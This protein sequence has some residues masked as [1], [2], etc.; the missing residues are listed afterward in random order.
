MEQSF[1]CLRSCS[2]SIR[3]FSRQRG[4]DCAYV[5]SACR[6]SRTS[7]RRCRAPGDGSAAYRSASIHS[8]APAGIKR[9][10]RRDWGWFRS[11][12]TVMPPKLIF[13][14]FF[15]Y[16]GI[17]NCYSTHKANVFVEIPHTSN[18]NTSHTLMQLI[19]P[20]RELF[21]NYYY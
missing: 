14:V 1:G 5:S 21:V 17:F 13:R 18:F 11:E 19:K 9:P 15:F 10:W 20:K 2:C 8:T 16:Y 4:R 12:N 3:H 7:R 6:S